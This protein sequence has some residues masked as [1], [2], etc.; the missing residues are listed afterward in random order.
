MSALPPVIRA[1]EAGPAYPRLRRLEAAIAAFGEAVLQ[2]DPEVIL[3]AG[4][5]ALAD[6][7]GR[8]DVAADA[9]AV[10]DRLEES[11][12]AG[13]IADLRHDGRSFRKSLR[14][15]AA[16]LEVEG[17]QAGAMIWLRLRPAQTVLAEAVTAH[18]FDV[19]P[20]PA[21]VARADGRLIAVN[22]A[23]LSAVGARSLDD[24]AARGLTFGRAA[25]AAV[26][27]AA[28]RGARGRS[29][30]WLDLPAGR[31]AVEILTAPLGDGLAA[32]W[33]LDVTAARAD[34][35][36]A[37]AERRA[38][39]LAIAPLAD[40]VAVFEA[41][42]RLSIANDALAALWGLDA[43]LIAERPTH[44]ELLDHL[45]QR[46]LLPQTADYASF[47]AQELARHASP[48]A[49]EA[50]W[51]LPD[52]RT[53]RVDS[54]PHP[55]GGLI[56]SLSDITAELRLKAQFNHLL[57]VQQAT[58]DKLTDA[59]AVFGADTRLRLHNEAFA[60]LWRIPAEQLARE[61]EFDD[62][63]AFCLR[64]LNDLGFWRAL[65]GRIADPD[66]LARA[67][68]GG[69]AAIDGPRLV[70]WQSRPLPDGATLVSFTDVTNAR[71]LEQALQEKA[72][73]LDLGDKLKREFV[74]AIS[75][76]LRT[77]LTTIVGYAEL[78][79]RAHSPERARD[80]L[81][82]VKSAAGTLARSIENIL[83][84]AELDAGETVLEP[85]DVDVS[86]LLA[87]AVQRSGPA[88][89]ACGADISLGEGSAGGLMR[90]DAGKLARVLDSLI[91]NALG[92]NPPP[93]SIVLSAQRAEGEVRL[94][95][96]D[97]GRGIPYHVQARIFERF[98]AAEGA[99]AGLGLSLVKGL[100][101]LHGGWVT[102]E[103]DPGQG[104]TFSCHLPERA[105]ASQGRPELF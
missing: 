30:V 46:R 48:Q 87:R 105:S 58:L 18:A 76:E 103:S 23:W 34:A 42:Q 10:I 89:A 82:A 12:V 33:A 49:V 53:L 72:D 20:A 35:R 98:G 83:D 64:R 54:R 19:L 14:T 3:L 94:R 29:T 45:R 47:K 100:V 99:A 68:A 65:K 81:A 25:D 52:G 7:A 97:D 78:L 69:E 63:A 70:S 6:C 86:D 51:R 9:G 5:A 90:A 37:N 17:G 62:V 93:R 104:A 41:G 101:E 55:G 61:P 27:E 43:A 4:E 28:R 84:V 22:H 67:P 77:P 92:Q 36:A 79:G 66:P 39:E 80:W 15:A 96:A 40:A 73:A 50:I 95:V 102:V 57:Q 8:L 88:A 59:V 24:A 16:T 26:R 60:R 21:W 44:G 56:L 71:A 32:A 11:E 1:P 31:R 2:I 38:L 13:A 85:G 75:R 91:D 74:A